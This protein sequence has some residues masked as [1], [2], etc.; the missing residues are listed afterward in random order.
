MSENPYELAGRLRKMWALVEALEC[1]GANFSSGEL[2]A[3]EPC[4]WA[5]VAEV[6]SVHPPSD[7]TIEM[8]IAHFHKRELHVAAIQQLSVL[9]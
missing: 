4:T 3:F 5:I 8:V 6:A 7:E 2:A 9:T 1:S